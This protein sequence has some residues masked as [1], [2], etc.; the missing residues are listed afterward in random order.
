MPEYIKQGDGTFSSLTKQQKEAIGLLS[1]GTFL[2]YF[3]LM[4]Y[5]HMA[6]LL[7]E[8]FFP[9]TDPHTASLLTAFAFCSISIF[10]PVGAVIFG[11]IG[12]HFGRKST[13]VITTLMM[14]ASCFTM[15]ILPTYA[16]IGYTASVI[17]IICRIIQGMSVMSEIVCAE[18]YLT[19][20]IAPPARYPAVAL[21]SVFTSLGGMFALAVAFI[22]TTFVLNWRY[23]F[24]IGSG[25][26]MVGAVAR[27][28]LRE[29]PEFADAKR[30][31]A[32]S[33]E[34]ANV[35]IKKLQDN[36]IIQEKV[37]K[38][39]LLS[40]FAIQCAAPVCFYLTYIHMGI[41]LKENFGYTPEQV[42]QQNLIVSVVNIVSVI[43]LT[44]LSYYI[45]PLKILK[46]RVAI[47]IAFILFYPYLLDH[48]TSGFHILLIQS[49]IGLFKLGDTPAVPILYKHFPVFKRFT[50]TGLSAAFS[51][52][53]TYMITSFGLIYLTEYFGNAGLLVILIPT[54]IGFIFGLLHFEKLEKATI[55][56]SGYN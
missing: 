1:I 54:A 45:Y 32:N 26:A 47:F 10:R 11:Y 22:M 51:R 7:N 19:E 40:L 16:E 56:S 35:D 5:I 27:T 41:V 38:I 49:F 33:F 17:M 28:R 44:I 43:I 50:M 13:V 53:L 3:D 29:T 8:L 14:A 24:W 20:S 18:L 48:A 15:A 6:V 21:T 36:P 12:D 30:R 55:K 52:I 4:L 37:N 34:Q 39:T 9:K 31:I 23:A 2:E 25:I 42:I 46:V